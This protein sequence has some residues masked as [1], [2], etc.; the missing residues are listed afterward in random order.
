MRE[1]ALTVSTLSLAVSVI[2][3]WIWAT[4]YF[5]T[6]ADA[7]AAHLE[8]KNQIRRAYLELK[9]DAGNTELAFLERGGV[10]PDERRQYD[11]QK[12]LVERMSSQLMEL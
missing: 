12:M 7:E 4:S 9:I 3:G 11:L 2:G 1:Q 5:M 6:R 8:V 10:T